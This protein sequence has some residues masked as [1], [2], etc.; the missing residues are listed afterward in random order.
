MAAKSSGKVPIN[1]YTRK[2][3]NGETLLLQSSNLCKQ[4]RTQGSE[5]SQYLEE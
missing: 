4:M 1:R 5:T 2:Y 3:P